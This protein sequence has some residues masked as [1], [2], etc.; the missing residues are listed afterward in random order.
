MSR[1]AEWLTGGLFIVT[2][3]V[4]GVLSLVPMSHYWP[5]GDTNVLTGE[6]SRKVESHYDDNFPVRDLGTNVWAAID[7]TLFNEGRQGVIVGKN[8][9]LFSQEEFFAPPNEDHAVSVNL[10][11]V[12]AIRNFLAQHK[13]PMTV[14]VV[15][16][17]ARVYQDK[18]AGRHPAPVMESLY[19][20]FMKTLD[21]A[22]INA[23]DL[24][25]VLASRAESG[26]PMFL[27]TDTHW[28]PEGADLFARRAATAIRDRYNG[29]AWSWGEQTFATT[30]E[31]ERV[32]RGDLL[33]YIPVAPLFSKFGPRPDHFSPR[34]THIVSDDASESQSLFG[35]T[36]PDVV[37]VGTSYSANPLWDF[38]GALRKY[39]GHDLIN[40]S[41]EGE[42]PFAP[43][44]QYLKSDDFSEHP[45]SLV[46]WEFPERY[47]AQPLDNEMAKNWFRQSG[48]LIAAGQT[49]QQTVH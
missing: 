19:Q 27:R 8:G 3:L 38:P 48:T 39:L 6:W 43:M 47:L 30:R 32:H 2:V 46:I 44:V 14:L 18:L 34:Q 35:A 9:W 41:E 24:A 25:P 37:L 7:Y 26:R 36:T 13:I 1:T 31:P 5:A 12:V 21:K 20:R 29:P 49:E 15:P 16:A 11:R 22:R 33:N 42:G 17:K 45:P 40:Q 23:P 10:D 28:T 4:L